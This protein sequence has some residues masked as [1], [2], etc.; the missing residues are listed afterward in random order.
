MYPSSLTIRRCHGREEGPVSIWVRRQRVPRNSRQ[1]PAFPNAGVRVGRCRRIS[2]LRNGPASPR[3]SQEHAALRSRDNRRKLTKA[4]H[5]FP[6]VVNKDFKTVIFCLALREKAR[7]H[8][9]C[10]KV[11]SFKEAGEET[12]KRSP[13]LRPV[14][15]RP[16]RIYE[17]VRLRWPRKKLE[18]STAQGGL[19]HILWP[20]RKLSD[21][22]DTRFS[23][24]HPQH[25]EV[26][27]PAAGVA[28]VLPKQRGNH[29][30]L[31]DGGLR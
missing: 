23:T 12:A 15:P 4:K 10:E 17:S 2:A 22:C 21:V 7:E 19:Y 8:F 16:A 30:G 25:R 1:C 29:C 20:L 27:V 18:Q 5:C 26:P 24:A 28:E 31:Q 3:G 14:L 6:P 13:L 9:F 11:V